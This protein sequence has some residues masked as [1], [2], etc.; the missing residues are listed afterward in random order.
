MSA[1]TCCPRSKITYVCIY[2]ICMCLQ[3]EKT[4]SLSS[5]CSSPFSDTPGLVPSVI[6]SIFVR[7]LRLFPLCW[8]LLLVYV[9]AHKALP[10]KNQNLP[11][12]SLPLVTFLSVLHFSDKFQSHSLPT[13]CLLPRFPLT[14][15]TIVWPPFPLLHQNF[16]GRVYQWPLYC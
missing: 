10:S 13:M 5:R 16:S 8:L 15:F 6:Y 2:C 4:R 11:S 3:F 9:Q 12:T 7:H 1:V 14:Q